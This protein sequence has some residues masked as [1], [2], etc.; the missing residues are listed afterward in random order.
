MVE[1]KKLT[2]NECL[3][4]RIGIES[5]FWETIESIPKNEEKKLELLTK[6]LHPYF[7]HSFF[8]ACQN[9]SIIGYVCGMDHSDNVY[10]FNGLITGQ[11][12]LFPAHLHINLS[13]ESRGLG[14][15][16]KLIQAVID[17]I[18]AQRVHVVTTWKNKNNSFYQK[19]GFNH[20][21]IFYHHDVSYIFMGRHNASLG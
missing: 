12:K 21:K 8:V 4:L 6:Y 3:E 13:V 15:G 16:S 17:D 18:G 5:I 14:I 20:H 19:M 9:E 11:L 2:L 10:S 7:H 1:I